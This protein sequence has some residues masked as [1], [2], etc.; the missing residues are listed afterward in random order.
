MTASGIDG[1]YIL[2]FP[3][4]S[5][6]IPALAAERPTIA[7]QKRRA[8]GPQDVFISSDLASLVP[9]FEWEEQIRRAKFA[10]GEKEHARKVNEANS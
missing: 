10:S 4:G 9:I 5:D 1:P 2:D 7:N 8:N 6:S 3:K